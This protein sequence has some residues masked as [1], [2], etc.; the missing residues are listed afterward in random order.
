VHEPD[1]VLAIDGEVNK[2]AAAAEHSVD[3]RKVCLGGHEDCRFER[4]RV[5]RVHRCG[6]VR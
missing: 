4:R 5:A 2:R 3:G 6:E 1:G